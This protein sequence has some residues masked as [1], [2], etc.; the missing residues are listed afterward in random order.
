MFFDN[1]CDAAGPLNFKPKVAVICA[2]TVETLRMC[3]VAGNA[4]D[5]NC[6]QCDSGFKVKNLNYNDHYKY[7][8]GFV[9]IVNESST[10]KSRYERRNLNAYPDMQYFRYG[11]L[12]INCRAPYLGEGNFEENLDEEGLR[13]KVGLPT[14]ISNIVFG[15]Y[16]NRIFPEYNLYATIGGNPVKDTYNG[17]VL[18][19]HKDVMSI[20]GVERIFLGNS[21]S[22]AIMLDM[23][24]WRPR[25]CNCTRLPFCECVCMDDQVRNIVNKL[26]VKLPNLQGHHILESFTT[27]VPSMWEFD[28]LAILQK[29]M[30]DHDYGREYEE[31]PMFF[32]TRGMAMHR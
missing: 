21:S 9:S 31:P 10:T 11:S 29:P 28:F 27:R 13:V 2:Y 12:C 14:D 24:W 20:C 7:A 8:N 1:K 30:N 22:M 19:D 6:R 5:V 32:F 25:Q 23:R 3:S 17:R 18:F 16:T 4:A 26:K 15:Y